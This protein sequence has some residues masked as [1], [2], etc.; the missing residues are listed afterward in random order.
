MFDIQDDDTLDIKL[1]IVGVGKYEDIFES[2]TSS[3]T[4]VYCIEYLE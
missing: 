1:C 4:E 3:S 2:Y